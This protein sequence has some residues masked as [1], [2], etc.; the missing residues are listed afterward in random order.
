MNYG[1]Y[2][3]DASYSLYVDQNYINK[4]EYRAK[5]WSYHVLV[6]F[7]DLKSAILKRNQRNTSTSRLF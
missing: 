3:M 5:K 7:K 1:H 4:Q 6:P 2:Y